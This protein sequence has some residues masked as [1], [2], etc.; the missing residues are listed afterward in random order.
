MDFITF[1]KLMIYCKGIVTRKKGVFIEL[2]WSV[3]NDL[4]RSVAV[5]HPNIH[6]AI[7]SEI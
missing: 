5:T 7:T 2:V 6:P 1:K 4:W 3:S